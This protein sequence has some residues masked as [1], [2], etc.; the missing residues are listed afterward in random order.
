MARLAKPVYESLPYAYL[1]AGVVL[2]IESYRDSELWWSG[3]CAGVG[4]LALVGGLAVWMHRRD[5]RATSADYLR[6]GK[7]VIDSDDIHG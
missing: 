1:L 6:R 4:L 5:F 3:L 2:L 7:S